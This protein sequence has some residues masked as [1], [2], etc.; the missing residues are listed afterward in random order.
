MW[1]GRRIVERDHHTVV[2][3]LRQLEAERAAAAAAEQFLTDE[4]HQVALTK[5]LRLAP[6]SDVEPHQ[7]D[8]V[9]E[10]GRLVVEEARAQAAEAELLAMLDEE[11]RC[12]HDELS[13]LLGELGLLEH[14][15]LCVDNEMDMRKSAPLDV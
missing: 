10:A 11:E 4:H 9:A 15:P 7:Q 12:G 2:E 8:L 6:A 14:L 13:E 1:T 3:W 5:L